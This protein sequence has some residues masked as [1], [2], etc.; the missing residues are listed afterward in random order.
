MPFPDGADPDVWGLRCPEGTT[1]A[2]R[3]NLTAR[4][5]RAGAQPILAYGL[6]CSLPRNFPGAGHLGAS[7]DNLKGWRGP[8]RFTFWEKPYPDDT[9]SA[10][11]SD[12]P[13]AK[14]FPSQLDR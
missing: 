4:S 3:Y 1:Q 8:E 6:R 5:V 13:A 2:E 12:F 10:L 11:S 14:A 7:T 9:Y